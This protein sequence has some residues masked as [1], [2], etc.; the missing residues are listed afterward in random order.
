[1]DSVLHVND[2]SLF[3]EKNFIAVL[4]SIQTVH[5]HAANWLYSNRLYC[6]EDKT[7]NVPQY[8]PIQITTLKLSKHWGYLLT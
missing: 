5:E 1:M 7:G 6:N 8:V 3:S 2:T 4:N